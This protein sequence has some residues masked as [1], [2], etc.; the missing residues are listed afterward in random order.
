MQH[1]CARPWNSSSGPQQLE[2][3]VVEHEILQYGGLLGV[4]HE[5]LSFHTSAA[6][7]VGFS[8]IEHSNL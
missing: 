4:Q 7:R 3:V 2:V 6:H 1:A 8:K 5:G